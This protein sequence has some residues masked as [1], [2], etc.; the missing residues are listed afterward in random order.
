MSERPTQPASTTVG[1]AAAFVFLWNS[2]YIA[3]E[4]GLG[5]APTLTLLFWRYA[6]LALAL[7][8][9]LWLR[10]RLLWP[11]LPTAAQEAFIGVMAH[12]V[13]LGCVM[14]ALGRGVPAGIVALVCAL[15]PMLT[16]ALSGPV[17]GERTDRWQWLGL[18]IGFAGVALVVGARVEAAGAGSLIGYLLP[19]GSVAG[20]TAASLLQRRRARSGSYGTLPLDLALF[21]Q[22]LATAAVVAL[23]AILVDGLAVDWNL[24]FLATMAWLVFGVSLGAYAA[25]WWLLEGV[26]A[27]RVASLFYLGPPVTMLM[28]WLAFGDTV[29]P[30]DLVG[31]GVVAV[32][33][34]LVQM[35][36]GGAGRS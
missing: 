4:Y 26:D 22:S 7:L 23:P 9:A 36:R 21:Y 11:G 6:A 34:L 8:P 16:G 20:I 28:G 2:G 32:G 29:E 5:S 14:L 18:V 33:V 1:L 24:P 31:L 19:F 35:G 27:T 30:A 3:V 10:R 12:G 15:Q 13:W 25:M 17:V